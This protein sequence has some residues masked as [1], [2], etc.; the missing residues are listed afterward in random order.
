[1][2]I[3]QLKAEYAAI[4]ALGKT[5]NRSLAA[6]E[7]AKLDTLKLEIEKLEREGAALAAANK[8]ETENR[9]IAAAQ[10]TIKNGLGSMDKNTYLRSLAKGSQD[11]GNKEV[12]ADV[13]RQFETESPIFAAHKNVQK[14]STGNA[15]SFTKI[16][17]GGAG[18]A[19]TEGNA[20]TADT[21]SAATIASVV[22]LT[23]SGQKITVTQ[24]MID[25]SAADIAQEVIVLG[26]AKATTKFD[27]DAVA[28]LETYGTPADTAATT[29]ALSD[30]VAAYFEL[31]N[32]N[33]NTNVKYICAPATAAAIVNMLNATDAPKAAVIGLSADS[34]IV[35]DHVTAGHV[36]V[37][38]PTLALAIGIKVPAR[39][40]VDE[41]SE[42]RVYEA[43]PRLAVAL[44]DSTAISGRKLKA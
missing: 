22:F 4:L 39:I 5:E 2:T 12:L 16:T 20:G 8:R 38:D 42:G 14:R 32:R 34:I 13:V 7:T 18:Y 28:A 35:D 17:S 19:K 15:F 25:D 6:A 3:E 24:E 31:P 43:Q 37:C 11:V 44:R 27:I 10:E 23:Y 40:F 26:S 9:S 41:V 33:R 1:M 36:L 29:W 30:L 21:A